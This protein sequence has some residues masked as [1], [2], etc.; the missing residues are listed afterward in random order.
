MKFFTKSITRKLLITILTPVLIMFLL[1]YVL[2]LNNVEK[3]MNSQADTIIKEGSEGMSCQI[4]GFFLEHCSIAEASAAND[5]FKAFFNVV[6]P[7]VKF[8]ETSQYGEIKRQLENV[9]ALDNENIMS[10]WIG[11]IDSNQ[12]MSSDGTV[13]GDDFN[14]TEREWYADVIESQG[15]ILS[16][17]YVDVGTGKVVVSLVAPVHNNNALVGVFGIDLSLDQLNEVMSNAKIG[18]TGYYIFL[19]KNGT[20][21]YSPAQDYILKSVND[22]PVSENA[23]KMISEGKTGNVQYTSGG[24]SLHGYVAD[25]GDTSWKA[26]SSMPDKEYGE[27]YQGLKVLLTTIII[28]IMILICVIVFISSNSIVRPLRKLATA[29]DKIAEGNLEVDLDI[30]T[31]DETSLVA[32]S[33]NRTV[34]RLKDYI[35]YINEISDLLA[36]I[37][38]GDLNIVFNQ[39]YDGDFAIVKEAL[40]DT[41]NMLNNTLSEF[42]VS[43]DQVASGS[44]QVASGAQALSQGTTEQASSIEELS[45]TVNTITEQIKET[46]ENAERAKQIANESGVATEQSQEQMRLMIEAMEEI[47]SASNEI[48]KIIK[49]ID[50]IAFQTN[51]LALNA[52]VEAARAGAAGKGFAVVAEEVRNLASKSAESAKSTAELIESSLDAI[53]KGSNIVSDTAKSLEEVVSG[54]KKSAEVIQD[55]ADASIEQSQAISQVNIGIGQISDVVQ[56][57]SATA[58]ESAAASEELS[59]QAQML[60]DLI[61]KFKLKPDNSSSSSSYEKYSQ[62]HSYS[63]EMNGKSA[64]FT[65]TTYIDL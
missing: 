13:T 5:T 34:L 10:T 38:N 33:F 42:N 58:E 7:G 9:V 17:P 22:L 37:G 56:T 16:E 65:Q 3:N 21:I 30:K 63:E 55:I 23:K 35:A 61:S 2:I 62:T 36:Q 24:V 1:M 26:V 40:L 19:S 39:A 4:N 44:N 43:A 8:D 45:S 60:K 29:A 14:I 20:I 31:S 41:S 49:N 28:I 25:I 15:A 27:M 11:D 54:S 48:G 64:K 12:V 51:I 18:K 59:G 47:S 46:A 32:D 53:E 52:A 50:D 57:N 6:T